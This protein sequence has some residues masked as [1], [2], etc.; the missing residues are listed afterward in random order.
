MPGAW[1]RD[2]W[3]RRSADC[4]ALEPIVARPGRHWLVSG[5]MLLWGEVSWEERRSVF[6]GRASGWEWCNGVRQVVEVHT[7]KDVLGAT[8]FTNVCLCLYLDD[9]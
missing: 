6:L 2:R 5:E 8:G 3:R 9:K 7:K 1:S 4:G